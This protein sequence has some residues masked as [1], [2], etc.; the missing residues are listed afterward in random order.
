VMTS[1]RL[2]HWNDQRRVSGMSGFT[3][4]IS[5]FDKF[6][7]ARKMLLIFDGAIS[8]LHANIANAVNNNIILSYLPSYCMH[9]LH[10]VWFRRD[11]GLP[12]NNYAISDSAL[13]P[14]N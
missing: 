5:H 6:K 3:K 9:E 12:I 7:T 8:H 4:C 14:S 2:S 10:C 1:P 13:I 11:W